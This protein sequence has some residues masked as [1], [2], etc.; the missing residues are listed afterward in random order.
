MVDPPSTPVKSPGNTVQDLQ[1]TP[2]LWYKIH[3]FVYD[4]HHFREKSSSQ[5]RLDSIVDASYIGMP[6]FHPDEVTRLKTTVMNAKGQTLEEL[7]AE[8]LN[9]RLK[10]RTKEF[11][12]SGDY[13]VCAAHDLAP[14][15]EKTLGIEPTDLVRNVEFLSL[16]ESSGLELKGGESFQRIKRMFMQRQRIRWE[17]GVGFYFCPNVTK[18]SYLELSNDNFVLARRSIARDKDVFEWEHISPGKCWL[19]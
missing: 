7:I 5:G 4:L 17:S 19:E 10:R 3:V 12:W 1:N 18:S 11:A 15:F 9:E 14:I 13:W 2:S 16:M 6:Y 8:T